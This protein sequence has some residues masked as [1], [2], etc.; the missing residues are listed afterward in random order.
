MKAFAHTHVGTCVRALTLFWL[1]W[2]SAACEENHE[3]TSASSSDVMHRAF[4]R[5]DV[6]SK[7][8]A[9]GVSVL[10]LVDYSLDQ[11]EHQCLQHEHKYVS[12]ATCRSRNAPQRWV[13][14]PDGSL[15]SPTDSP[16][17]CLGPDI[18]KNHVVLTSDTR[19]TS[20]SLSPSGQLVLQGNHTAD[21]TSRRFLHFSQTSRDLRLHLCHIHSQEQ[22][23][24]A[25]GEWRG[26]QVTLLGVD[27]VAAI[28]EPAYPNT[29]VKT[30][31]ELSDLYSRPRSNTT[32]VKVVLRVHVREST[33]P[34]LPFCA[35]RDPSLTVCA[36]MRECWW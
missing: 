32:M 31:F 22:T 12:V 1:V 28:L 23:N 30:T 14:F 13:R 15:C 34:M 18:S 3:N 9:T 27:P 17:A 4:V 33:T 2:L 21:S 10:V 35:L 26:S 29:E 36:G 7:S 5:S 19:P 8:N 16:K 25:F 11:T 24:V 6:L 20:W